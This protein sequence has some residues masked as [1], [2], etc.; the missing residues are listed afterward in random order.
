MAREE[1]EERLFAKAPMKFTLDMYVNAL[2]TLQLE[3][4][5]AAVREG[6]RISAAQLSGAYK[7]A[8]KVVHPDKGGGNVAAQQCVHARDVIQSVNSHGLAYGK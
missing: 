1:E 6:H 2:G 8:M 5:E 4:D 7:L 3:Y